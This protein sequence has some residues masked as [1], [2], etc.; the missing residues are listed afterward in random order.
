MNAI[1]NGDH[2]ELDDGAKI[3]LVFNKS[4]GESKYPGRIVVDA[5]TSMEHYD[6]IMGESLLPAAESM[7]RKI[8][9]DWDG[10]VCKSRLD[11]CQPCFRRLAGMLDLTVRLMALRVPFVWKYPEDGLHPMYQGNIAD[12]AISLVM[13]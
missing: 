7:F 12:V 13:P 8:I 5:A 9:H 11:Q 4:H 10:Q 3:T 2:H 6:E 1:F